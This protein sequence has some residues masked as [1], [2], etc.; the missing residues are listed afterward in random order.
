MSEGE[1]EDRE[2]PAWAR[3]L[4][5]ELARGRPAR[6]GR[7]PSAGRA[8]GDAAGD[9]PPDG[10]LREAEA[11]WRRAIAL[12]QEAAA[13]IEELEGR[14]EHLEEELATARRQLAAHREDAERLRIEVRELRPPAEQ[15]PQRDPDRDPA[16][17]GALVRRLVRS[18]TAWALLVMAGLLVWTRLVPLNLGFWGDETFTVA[19][20]VDPGPRGTFGSYVPNNHMLFSLLAWATTSVLGRAEAIYRVWSVLPALAAVGIVAHVLWRRDRPACAVIFTF[21]ALT[22]P[23]HLE[24]AP[25]ARGYGLGFLA[26]AA[27]L[28][29]SLRLEERRDR[30]AGTTLTAG[31]LAG[32]WALPVVVLAFAG[33]VLVLLRRAATRRLAVIT[34]T[35]VA[36]ASLVFYAPV[37][38]D[39]IVATGQEFGE[40]LPWH[41]PVTGPF[42]LLL[43]R[44][45]RL[46]APDASSRVLFAVTGVVLAL[47]ALRSMRIERGGWGLVAHLVVPVGLTFTTLT[48]LQLFVMHRFASFVLFHVLALAAFGLTGLLEGAER[49]WGARATPE[50]ERL[51]A[52][53][54]VLLV[55]VALVAFARFWPESVEV[56]HVPREGYREAAAI[57]NTLDDIDRVVVN[58]RSI[59]GFGYYLDRDRLQVEF[60]SGDELEPVVCG[61]PAPFVYIDFRL[62]TRNG[63]VDCLEERASAPIVIQQRSGGPEGWMRV[64][65]VRD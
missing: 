54:A 62:H 31:A 38:G 50:S 43:E 46:L 12:R 21:L 27:M 18:P 32:I 61:D 34:A 10:D 65:I 58:S 5:A 64:W 29:A 60:P 14:T 24:L 53:P 36:V 33:H 44:S 30:A 17:V 13:R 15:R 16:T 42:T 49:L 8:E 19:R 56:G 22:S 25:Q 59:S 23:V 40:R 1:P 9:R 52:L 37:L 3:E 26:G 48:V 6:T 41:A 4:D 45:A 39:L 28:W 47:G 2:W 35:V 20:Y 57:V 51:T 11:R 55:I 7:S 63:D